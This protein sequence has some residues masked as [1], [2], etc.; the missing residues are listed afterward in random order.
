MAGSGS[1]PLIMY[2]FIFPP[3]FYQPY[4]PFSSATGTPG[5]PTVTRNNAGDKKNKIKMK[6]KKKTANK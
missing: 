1:A 6:M 5:P 3:F 2:H 4:K